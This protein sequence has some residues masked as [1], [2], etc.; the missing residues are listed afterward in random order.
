M[1]LDRDEMNRMLFMTLDQY[2]W[3]P[4]PQNV[5]LTKGIGS[6]Q[7]DALEEFSPLG[8][9]MRLN[10]LPSNDS[11]ITHG[12]NDA[13]LKRFSEDFD[14]PKISRGVFEQKVKVTTCRV[15][16]LTLLRCRITINSRGVTVMNSSN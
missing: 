8:I 10:T 7:G 1:L 14:N 15:P 4:G 11:P 13:L 16:L 2:P 5:A 3:I 9:F 6:A 12:A